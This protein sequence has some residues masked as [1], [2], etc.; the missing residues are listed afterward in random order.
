VL[1]S[2]VTSMP[3]SPFSKA[4]Y[5]N[6]GSKLP[7]YSRL[8]DLLPRAEP[9]ILP[10]RKVRYLQPDLSHTYPPTPPTDTHTFLCPP[11]H[12]HT[13]AHTHTPPPPQAFLKLVAC[14]PGAT[15]E[16]VMDS[17]DALYGWPA[18]A[19]GVRFTKIVKRIQEVCGHTP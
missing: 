8:V 1:H 17:S 10:T 2:H 18:A 3:R 13:H 15:L 11:P 14:P 7:G 12:T 19:L 5:S 4:T 16:S 9:A 6:Q